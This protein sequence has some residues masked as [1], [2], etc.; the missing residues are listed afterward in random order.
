MYSLL[1][2]FEIK[3]SPQLHAWIYGFFPHSWLQQSRMGGFREIVFLGHGLLVSFFVSMGLVLAAGVWKNRISL[4]MSVSNMFIVLFLAVVLIL[5]KSLAS[6]VYGIAAS[7]AILILSQKTLSRITVMAVVVIMIYPLLS[8]TN[9][10]PHHQLVELAQEINPERAQSLEFRFKNE[11][12]LLEHAYE[13][14][15]FGWGGW[16][17]NRVFDDET[18]ADKTVTDGKWI[19][20]FGMYG[21]FGMIAEFGL[22][23]I[24]IFR[25]SR[26]LKFTESFRESSLLSIHI[27]VVGLILVDQIPN[28]SLSP[29]YWFLIGSLMGRT[30]SVKRIALDKVNHAVLEP[31][32]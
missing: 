7:I 2:L 24:T 3:M 21:W 20:T 25:A 5:S 11:E 10:F 27:V 17:R 29:Y 28:S 14:P 15:I 4:G 16:G 12:I 26:S 8:V 1:V 19:I 22:I 9:L 23:A 18:G 31:I 13:K 32:K 30:E 6:L